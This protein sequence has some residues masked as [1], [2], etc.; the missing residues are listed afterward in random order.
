[1]CAWFSSLK[2]CTDFIEFCS[3]EIDFLWSFV[4]ED[5]PTGLSRNQRREEDDVSDEEQTVSIIVVL[6]L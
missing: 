6:N 1:M 2:W 3:D 5:A 4:E